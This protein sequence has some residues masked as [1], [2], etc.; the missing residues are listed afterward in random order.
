[1]AESGARSGREW[2]V[3]ADESGLRLDAFLAKA[4]RLGSRGRAARALARGQVFIDRREATPADAARRVEAGDRVA[5]WLDRPGSAH[6][7]HGT[8]GA[9]RGRLAILYEDDRLIVVNKPPG[10]LTVPLPRR[11]EAP[12]LVGLLR[13]HL[14]GKAGRRPLAVHRI[15]RDTSGLVVFATRPDAQRALTEQFR[16]HDP[17]RVYL[18]IVRGVPVPSAGTWRDRFL[19]DDARTR[20][21]SAGA[22]DP[23]GHEAVCLYRVIEAFA[24]A[25]L[26]EIRLVTGLRNQIR[27]QAGLRGHGL[28]GERQYAGRAEPP[29]GVT[30][31]RQALHASRLSFR[32]PASGERLTFEA[33]LPPDLSKVLRALEPARRGS[34]QSRAGR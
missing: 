32:H 31:P 24:D 8:P 2:I 4:G 22:G 33:P 25:A 15:D 14:R 16:R 23:P 5:L 29:R 7:R 3:G 18:A 17:E 12:S 27:L 30:C 10:L 28:L 19:W 13:G 34:G 6:R 1:M 9:A 21:T 20:Q 11:A 26:V